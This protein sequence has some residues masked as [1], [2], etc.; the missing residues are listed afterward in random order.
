MTYEKT[1]GFLVVAC[2]LKENQ[3]E[4]VPLGGLTDRQTF[5]PE[6]ENAH[7]GGLNGR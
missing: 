7:A 1:T 2:G 3:Q 5:V 6:R 4:E